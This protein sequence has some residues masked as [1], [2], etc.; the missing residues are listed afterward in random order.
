MHRI[1]LLESSSV[2]QRTGPQVWAPGSA[3][4]SPTQ[5]VPAP[6][7]S[8]LRE[9]LLPFRR[10]SNGGNQRQPKFSHQIGSA[11][12]PTPNTAFC[13]NEPLG[14]QTVS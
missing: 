8:P 5:I 13:L 10:L 6:L 9:G 14:S 1:T 2:V 3:F 11:A 4:P 12:F 7:L